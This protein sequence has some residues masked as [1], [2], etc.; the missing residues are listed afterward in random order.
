VLEQELF[1]DGDAAEGICSFIA[2]RV[3]DFA[4]KARRG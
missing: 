1:T 2:K 4:A 3:P